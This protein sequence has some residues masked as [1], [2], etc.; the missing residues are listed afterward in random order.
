M[1]MVAESMAVNETYYRMRLAQ[2]KTPDNCINR[3]T[4]ID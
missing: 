3:E 4:V 1:K 2:G